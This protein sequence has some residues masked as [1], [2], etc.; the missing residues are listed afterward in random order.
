LNPEDLPTRVTVEC[1]WRFGGAWQIYSIRKAGDKDFVLSLPVD[2]TD[3]DFDVSVEIDQLAD[4]CVY[5]YVPQ[6]ARVDR[7]LR[8]TTIVSYVS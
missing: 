1:Y 7:L 4:V 3:I 8:L 2:V 6:K 5:L